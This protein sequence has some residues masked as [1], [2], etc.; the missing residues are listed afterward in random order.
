MNWLIHWL[1]VIAFSI[2]FG[3]SVIGGVYYVLS[4]AGVFS[5]SF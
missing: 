5:V 1:I 2:M 3:I 4:D